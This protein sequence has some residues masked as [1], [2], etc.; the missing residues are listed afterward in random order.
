MGI[1]LS[2]YSKNQQFRLF[3]CVK[4]H[5]TNPLIQSVILT[6]NQPIKYSYNETLRKSLLTYEKNDAFMLS[7]KNNEFVYEKLGIPSNS[8]FQTCA[9]INLNKLN[10]HLKNFYPTS[11]KH[12]NTPNPKKL[13]LSSSIITP[14]NTDLFDTVTHEFKSFVQK[15][16]T[17]DSSHI[18]YIRSIVRGNCNSNIIF[19]NIGGEYRYCSRINRHHKRNTTAIFIDII[20]RTFTIRCKDSDC[21]HTNLCWHKI[22]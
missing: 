15:L 11:T 19:F 18:G 20:N 12:Q 3:D 17:N 8:I 16:I 2:V 5:K 14:T 6:S 1:D 10:Y 9:L 7:E 4:K 22:E 21:R 13:N